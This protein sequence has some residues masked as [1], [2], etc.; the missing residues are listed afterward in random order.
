VHQFLERTTTIDQPFFTYDP[1]SGRINGGF[2]NGITILGVDILPTELPRESSA[3][4]GDALLGIVRELLAAKESQD[5]NVKG[6]NQN[7]LTAGLVSR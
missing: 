3:H 2:E 4:F 6:I 5:S 1:L 7:H